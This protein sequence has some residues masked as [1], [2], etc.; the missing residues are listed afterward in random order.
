MKKKTKKR[1]RNLPSLQDHQIKTNN[2]YEAKI[3]QDSETNSI[4][5]KPVCNNTRSLIILDSKTPLYRKSFFVEHH[6]IETAS[7]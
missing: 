2:R 5:E 3:C 7:L 4:L 1:S 6:N